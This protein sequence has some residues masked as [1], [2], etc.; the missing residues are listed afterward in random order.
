MCAVRLLSQ[1]QRVASYKR[2]QQITVFCLPW[3]VGSQ[4]LSFTSTYRSEVHC[5]FSPWQ[6]ESCDVWPIIPVCF[7]S[8]HLQVEVLYLDHNN[9]VTLRR[10]ALFNLTHLQKVYLRNN[11]IQTFQPQAFHHLPLLSELYL[12]KNNIASLLPDTFEVGHQSCCLE[13]ATASSA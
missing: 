2:D 1:K 9:F 7:G 6:V 10:G 4:Q 11:Q 5:Q 12:T 13:S 8:L 3:Q